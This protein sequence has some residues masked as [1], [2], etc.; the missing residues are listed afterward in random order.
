MQLPPLI[1][2]DVCLLFAVG[3]I[4]LLL[5]VEFSSPYYGQIKLSMNRRRM[6]NL[7]YVTGI[8]FLITVGITII[9]ILLK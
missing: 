4:V 7:A 3:A 5:T 2:A 9:Q 1:F 6:K 8:V